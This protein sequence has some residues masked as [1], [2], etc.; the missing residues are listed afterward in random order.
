M[1]KW[2]TPFKCTRIY[3]L[4]SRPPIKMWTTWGLRAWTHLSWRKRSTNWSRKKSNCS[5]RSPYSKPK[6]IRRISRHSSRPHPNLERNRS[7]MRSLV[8]R[9]MNSPKWSNTSN[10]T[11][12]PSNR[13][14]LISQRSQISISPQTNCST[15]WEQTLERIEISKMRF[16]AENLGTRRKDCKE[17]SCFSRSRWPRRMS[18][19]GS[20]MMSRDSR[21]SAWS[22]TRS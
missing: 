10:K 22:S 20:Q 1:K 16:W 17:S 19:R 12:S 7:R 2:G 5:P 9:S 18:S 14:S 15:I 3:K 21:R 4:N 13:D 11:S 6:A 8:K